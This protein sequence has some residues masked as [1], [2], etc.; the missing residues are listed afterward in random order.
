ME[1]LTLLA[2]IVTVVIAILS[3]VMVRREHQKLTGI[4]QPWWKWWPEKNLPKN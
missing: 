1:N 2:A 3:L 4:K